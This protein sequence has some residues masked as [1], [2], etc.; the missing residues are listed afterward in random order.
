MTNHLPPHPIRDDENK[1]LRGTVLT[2]FKQKI[3]G[4]TRTG[5][6]GHSI[7]VVWGIFTNSLM[8]VKVP[9]NHSH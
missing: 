3:S 7:L 5:A 6:S 9:Y 2:Q 1:A 8:G 4:R